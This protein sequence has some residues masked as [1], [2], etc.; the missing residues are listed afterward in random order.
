LQEEAELE[1][2]VRLVGADALPPDQQLTLEVARMIREIF[3]QQNAYHAVDT[4]CPPERQ[5][6]IISAIKKYSDLG[7]KAVKLDVPTKDVGLPDGSR[8]RGQVL[9]SSK[10]IVVVQVFEGTAGI[11]RQSTV[12][13]LGE[14]IKLNV[15]RDMLGR[16]LSGAGEPIDGGPPIV[17]EKRVE[18]IGA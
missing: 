15:S 14:T 6:K 13:F 12:K 8:K 2:I 3:L 17:P 16:I 4:F 7:Q 1:E 9:D 5:F 18:I 10:D 11:D